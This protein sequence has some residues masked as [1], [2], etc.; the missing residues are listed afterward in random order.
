M[1]KLWKY[2][3][4][5]FLT[6]TRR[7]YKKAVKLS[8]YHDADLNT[9]KTTEPLLVPIYDRYHAKHVILVGEYTSWRS[10]ESSQGGKTTAL[11]QLLNDTYNDHMDT[12]DVAI[13]GVFL[14][15]TPD[16]KAIFSN[17]R[18]SFTSGSID[19]R[20]NA[21]DTLAKN[22]LP[23]APLAAVMGEVAAAY[24]ALDTARDK[25][26]GAKGTVKTGSGKVEAARVAAM[27]LQHRDTGFAMD[28]FW[29]KP[30]YIE[31]MFDLDTLRTRRQTHFT[32]TLDPLENYAVVTRTMLGDDEIKAKSN[33]NASI[34]LY[35][36]TTPNGTN[37]DFVEIL[38]NEEKTFFASDFNV[39]DFGTHRYLTVI[40]TSV[41]ETTQ[42]I[43][44]LE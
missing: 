24:T 42:F 26:E 32:G 44:D 10:A 43:I 28:A 20:I 41:S 27:T 15:G 12:W 22:M 34:R 21:Y 11:N 39:A 23:Y 16:Y 8:N 38:A 7:N 37:S 40:N 29:D 35:L 25:Q 17:G 19:E 13:Q 18:K 6:A 3:E 2:L 4:N 33:G 1:K 9:K 5:Q 30:D 36:A 14:K 31:S